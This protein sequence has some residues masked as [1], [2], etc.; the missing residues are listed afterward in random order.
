VGRGGGG[1]VGG[2]CR[3]EGKGRNG[4][5]GKRRG[6]GGRRGNAGGGVGRA[7]VSGGGWIEGERKMG[8]CKYGTRRSI[9]REDVVGWGGGEGMGRTVQGGVS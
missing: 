1:G 9:S 6:R 4:G 3:R 7:G 5:G 8:L 2:C